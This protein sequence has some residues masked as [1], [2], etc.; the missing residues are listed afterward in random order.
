[1]EIISKACFTSVCKNMCLFP[2][3]SPYLIVGIN[4]ENYGFQIFTLLV[5]RHLPKIPSWTHSYCCY[6]AETLPKV[7]NF[8]ST[9]WCISSACLP[10]SQPAVRHSCSRCTATKVLHN[11]GNHIRFMKLLFQWMFIHQAMV[12][13]FIL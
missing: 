7:I 11:I 9:I 2:M 3:V 4:Q 10:A 6:N 13:P 5:T 8:W 1:M 12:F